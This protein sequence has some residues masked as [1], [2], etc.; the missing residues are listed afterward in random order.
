MAS[1]LSWEEGYCFDEAISKPTKK[2]TS[3]RRS[4]RKEKEK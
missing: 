4:T 2:K 3:P 1:P